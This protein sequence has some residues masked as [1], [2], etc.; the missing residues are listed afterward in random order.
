M[1]PRHEAETAVEP[2]P[3]ADAQAEAADE[4]ADP[5]PPPSPAPHPA[6]ADDAPARDKAATPPPAINKPLLTKRGY[7]IFLLITFFIITHY[8]LTL[9]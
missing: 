9:L 4:A 3:T 7:C 8:N 6:T 1:V 5:N 2:L